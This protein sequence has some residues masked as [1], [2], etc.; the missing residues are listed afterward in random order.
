MNWETVAAF[1]NAAQAEMA[2]N[3]LEGNGIPVIVADEELCATVW[4]WSNAVGG[5]K[6]RVPVEYLGRAA[7]LLEEQQPPPLTD[8]DIADAVAARPEVAAALAGPGA[9]EPFDDTTT[10]REV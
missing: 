8:A 7:R 4:S 1:D 10:D 5:I 6:L 9:P 3:L 2:K